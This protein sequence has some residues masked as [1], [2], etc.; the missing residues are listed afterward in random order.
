MANPK[1]SVPPTPPGGWSSSGQPSSRPPAAALRRGDAEHH[2]ATPMPRRIHTSRIAN[3]PITPEPASPGSAPQVADGPSDPFGSWPTWRRRE[4]TGAPFPTAPGF[5]RGFPPRPPSLPPPGPGLV[6]AVQQVT[7]ERGTR[8]QHRPT[9]TAPAGPRATGT[10]GSAHRN[11]P[12]THSIQTRG[13]EL[14]GWACAWERPWTARLRRAT[15]S[16]PRL[17]RMSAEAPGQ[18]AEV[19]RDAVV[20]RFRPTEPDA[21]W[22]WAC[23]EHR[24]IGRHRLS[25]FAAV[26]LKRETQQ[27]VIDLLLRA[28]EL[29]GI[30]PERNKKYC[31][32]TSAAEVLDLGFT[33]WRD[34]DDE[35]R[36]E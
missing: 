11:H 35:E 13:P 26:R 22:N 23:K 21:V 2:N 28:S 18:P 29:A 24:R 10:S 7:A 9:T 6:A 20:I 30:D 16:S 1:R 25:V 19:P 17:Y 8:R 5:P 15:A 31:V 4:T 3:S 34:G 36:D 33:F 12:L 14:V 27:D 32:C